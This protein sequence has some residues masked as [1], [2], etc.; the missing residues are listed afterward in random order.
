LETS[1][2]CLVVLGVEDVIFSDEA[3]LVR[4]IWHIVR[5][6]LVTLVFILFQF[7]FI[8]LVSKPLFYL[9][10]RSPTDVDCVSQE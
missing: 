2:H 7:D 9:H 10:T 3:Q 1:T 8:P 5:H 6:N 4:N